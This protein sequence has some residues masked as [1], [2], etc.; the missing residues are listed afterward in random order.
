MKAKFTRYL[1]G[2]I[3]QVNTILIRLLRDKTAIFF[4]FLFPLIFLF[5]FGTIFNNKEL[6]F[7]IGVIDHANTEISQ[8]F[9]T[10]IKSS[11]LKLKIKEL[12]FLDQATELLKRSEVDG[13]LELEKGFGEI[14]PNN[15]KPQGTLKVLFNRGSEQAGST[16]SAIFEQMMNG[17]NHSIGHPEA[18][19][20]VKAEAFGDS[21][22]SNFDYTF[23]G[24]V[25]FS[26]MNMAI[27]GL[28]HA[29]PSDKQKGVFKRLKASSLTKS[30]LIISHAIAYGTMTFM[31]LTTMI[32]AGI[33]FFHF[34]M[35]G[36]WL[37]FAGFMILS[38]LMMVGIGI[39]IG[40]WAQ[41]ENQ[42]SPVSNIVA[43][44]MMFLS[45]TFIPVFLFPEWLKIISNFIP[46]TPIVDGARMIM[47]ENA[48]FIDVLPQFGAIC[49]WIFVIYILAIRIFRWE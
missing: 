3:G 14:N 28:S 29:L 17:M 38:I 41:N 20:K 30:Q 47:T 34:N 11:K 9:L 45:G 31:S 19:F 22:L 37:L 49:G 27:F 40:G 33:S 35:R 46:V 39:A 36:S 26:L 18:P 12:D 32:I 7:S 10:E 15:Q 42:A 23:T 21:G 5:V 6:G 13:I 16:L 43:M 44:P 1:G 4:T 8:H 24:L 25:A 48:E 2:I